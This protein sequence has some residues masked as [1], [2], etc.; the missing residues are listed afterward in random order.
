MKV[1][2]I[3]LSYILLLQVVHTTQRPHLVNIVQAGKCIG[4]H[5]KINIMIWH[6]LETHIGEK[7]PIFGEK[8]RGVARKG[9]EWRG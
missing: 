4:S 5:A 2:T 7:V 6:T 1:K 8:R 3:W 9:E